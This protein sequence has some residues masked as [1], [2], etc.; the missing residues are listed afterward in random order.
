MAVQ[1]KAKAREMKLRVVGLQYR[2]SK[3]SRYVLQKRLPLI[4]RFVR[5]PENE[6]DPNAVAVYLKS[7]PW[8]GVKLGYLARATA[9]EIAPRLDNGKLKVSR[10]IVTAVDA[11]RGEAEITVRRK[12]KSLQKKTI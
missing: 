5:E 2:L 8:D 7:E 11:A 12:R 4:A 3:S 10:V 9:S 1:Q 6:S